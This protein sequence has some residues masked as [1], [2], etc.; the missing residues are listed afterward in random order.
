MSAAKHTPGA[1]TRF[2]EPDPIVRRLQGRVDQLLRHGRVKDPELMQTAVEVLSEL[3]DATQCLLDGMG[4]PDNGAEA[5]LV[6]RCRAVIARATGNT[7]KE[8]A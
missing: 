6:D 5:F 4:T 2:V 8:Q 1:T 7:T 3:I